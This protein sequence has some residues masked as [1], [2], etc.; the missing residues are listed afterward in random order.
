MF[1]FPSLLLLGLFLAQLHYSVSAGSRQQQHI[2][3]HDPTRQALRSTAQPRTV[4]SAA[5]TGAL[6]AATGLV[7]PEVLDSTAAADV[8]AVVQPV[9]AQAQ[10]KAVLLLHLAGMNPGM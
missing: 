4:P 7:P 8:E 10:P 5:A 3:L 2:V 9:L 6:C 1:K